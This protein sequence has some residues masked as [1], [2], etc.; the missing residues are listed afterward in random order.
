MSTRPGVTVGVTERDAA[1]LFLSRAL[2]APTLRRNATGKMETALQWLGERTVD[3]YGTNRQRLTELA[4]RN[5]GYRLLPD[6]RRAV[7]GGGKRQ[8]AAPRFRQSVFD[9]ARASGLIARSIEA[10]GLN[11]VDVAPTRE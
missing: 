11:G 2:H 1:D 9:D 10:A 3:A 7:G 6:K 8:Q 5:P 4:A